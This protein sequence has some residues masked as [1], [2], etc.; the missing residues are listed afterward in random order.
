MVFG[1]AGQSQS[2]AR[3]GFRR[4]REGRQR[5]YVGHAGRV[6]N[7]IV[8]S[9]CMGCCNRQNSLDIEDIK[10]VPGCDVVERRGES[11]NLAILKADRQDVAAIESILSHSGAGPEL[12]R[13][14]KETHLASLA[15]VAATEVA[16][17]SNLS[18]AAHCQSPVDHTLTCRQEGRG[19]MSSW[20][21]WTSSSNLRSCL[22]MPW[23][24]SW[25]PLP[26]SHPR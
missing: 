12:V 20:T 18:V 11:V 17:S 23:R 10:R 6:N 14:G 2:L 8:S 13:E 26:S 4:E 19:R 5:A 25:R 24:R 16:A 3:Q 22:V 7:I 15:T 1:P 21:C 9:D